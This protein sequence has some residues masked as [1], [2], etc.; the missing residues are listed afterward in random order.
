M[1]KTAKSKNVRENNDLGRSFDDL[2]Y[3]IKM[4]LRN[5]ADNLTR[6]VL[7]GNGMM[8]IISSCPILSKTLNRSDIF[9]P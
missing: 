5:S 7:K 4:F 1:L 9:E 6:R 3:E 8:L 2:F